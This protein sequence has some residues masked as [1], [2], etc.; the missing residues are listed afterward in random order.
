MNYPNLP[1]NY[2]RR[3]PRRSNFFFLFILSFMALFL[4]MQYKKASARANAYQKQVGR[5]QAQEEVG[6][7]D[8]S[9]ADISIDG[10]IDGAAQSIPRGPS[11]LPIGADTPKNGD[12]E[13][14]TDILEETKPTVIGSVKGTDRT[15]A[16]DWG[17]EVGESQASD[18]GVIDIAKKP[19]AKTTKKG[20][21]ELGEV[22]KPAATAP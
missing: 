9:K 15:S 13:V 14:D 8:F 1:G 5:G 3:P 18:Q 10:S 16:G 4:F 6:V 20:D 17:L 11:G 7:P 21:W 22:D 2:D 12:W 19:E